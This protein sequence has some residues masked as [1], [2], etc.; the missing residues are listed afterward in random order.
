MAVGNKKRCRSVKL[1]GKG[2]RRGTQFILKASNVI[3]VY[4]KLLVCQQK[5]K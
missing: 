3:R 1:E 5:E 4:Q 2:S